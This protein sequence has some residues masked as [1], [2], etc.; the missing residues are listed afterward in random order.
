LSGTNAP[1]GEVR[2]L[3]PAVQRRILAYLRQRIASPDDPRQFGRPLNGGRHGFWRYR[4]GAYR[5]V[6][7]IE[8]ERLVVLILA[9]GHRKE[10]YE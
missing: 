6:C 2:R 7:R 9:V 1:E 10:V 4:I 3:D 5:L 8:Q